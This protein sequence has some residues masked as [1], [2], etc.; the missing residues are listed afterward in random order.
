MASCKGGVYHG[1]LKKKFLLMIIHLH[2][3]RYLTLT[4]AAKKLIWIPNIFLIPLSSVTTINLPRRQPL[5]LQNL[6]ETPTIRFLFMEAPDSARPIL[7]IPS[8]ITLSST[9]KTARFCML[10]V[11]NLQMSWS[12]QSVTEIIPLCPNSAKNTEILMYF[13]SMIFSLL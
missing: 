7:C 8:L 4:A 2:L 12:R 9:M 11:R 10:P 6:R 3:Q 13:L 5:L 1:I